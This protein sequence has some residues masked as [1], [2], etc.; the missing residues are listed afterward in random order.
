MATTSDALSNLLRELCTADRDAEAVLRWWLLP[1]DRI[2]RYEVVRPIGR[3][4]FGVVYE[5]RD[6]ERGDRVALKLLLC[7]ADGGPERETLQREI[8]A[9]RLRHPNIAAFVEA[10]S[11]DRGPY[12]VFEYVSGETLRRRL[13]RGPL[14]LDEVVSIAV[15]MARALAHTHAHGVLHRDVKPGNVLLPA[16]G[17]PKLIDF[18]LSCVIGGSAPRGS[19]TSRYMSPEQQRGEPEDARTDLF[20]LGL[21]IGEMATGKP[22]RIPAEADPSLSLRALPRVLRALVRDLVQPDPS[23]RP[24]SA[25]DVLARLEAIRREL[26]HSRARGVPACARAFTSVGA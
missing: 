20:A 5:A 24:R 1:G 17:E 23:R 6:R 21:L 11:S 26:R 14:P 10:G 25:D 22:L 12:A 7:D 16:G 8:D 15:A 19:G 2:G 13:R 4:G 3:G 18:G 9:G